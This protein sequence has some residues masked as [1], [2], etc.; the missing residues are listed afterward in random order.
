MNSK[1]HEGLAIDNE[2]QLS[3][4]EATLELELMMY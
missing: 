2:E 3:V 1:K 4:L